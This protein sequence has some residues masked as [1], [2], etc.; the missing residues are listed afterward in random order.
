MA[1][2]KNDK[3]AGAVTGTG[4]PVQITRPKFGTVAVRIRGIT[5]YVQ[6]KFSAKAMTMMMEQQAAGSTARGKK[7]RD[8]K[9]F[10]A[11]CE[12]ATHKMKGGGFGIPAPAFRAAMISACR[13]VDYK[14]TRAKMGIFV[15][16]DGMD[17]EGTTPL[18]RIT[19]GVPHRYDAEVRNSSGVIDIRSR[20]MWDV[21]W[22]AVVKIR[23][24][25]EMFTISDVANLMMRVGQQVGI[26]EGRP[27]SKN[28]VGLGY[29]LFEIVE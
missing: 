7:K 4:A 9:D 20:P 26:G 29:G 18:V 24:D 8:P 28:S 25:A 6:H 16:Q 22:E 19:K 21:G 10:D 17:I 1:K 5:P 15:I 3:A 23:Y 12:A 27:D 14:M 13:I 11:N 2:N